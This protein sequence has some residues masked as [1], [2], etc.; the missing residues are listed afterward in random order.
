MK[1]TTFTDYSLRVLI[2]LATQPGRR[3][4][5]AQIAGA[6]EVSENHLVKVVHYLG[7]N[8]WLANVRGKG[9]GLELAH[10]PSRINVGCV[11]R[12]TE[13]ATVAAECF[14]DAGSRCVIARSCRL[15]GVLGEAVNAFYGV[16]DRYTLA[17]IV[18]NRDELATILFVERPHAAAIRTRMSA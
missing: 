14:S 3:A 8:G 11:V 4:T 1:L 13:G 7:K 5:I 17:D 10:V 18:D 9:G 6:F 12:Q 2:Y 16:L 15:K